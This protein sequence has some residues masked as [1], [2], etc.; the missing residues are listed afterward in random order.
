MYDRLLVAVDHSETAGRV[1][2]AAR[3]MA[4][5]S[6]GEVWVLHVREKEVVPRAGFLM[7]ESAQDAQS[8]AEGAVRVLHDASIKAHH[9]VRT[10]IHGQAA[11][12][13]VR[14][15][16]AHDAG[17]I[18]MGSRGRRDLT[19]LVLGSAAHEVIRLSRQ[20]VLVVR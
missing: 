7:L 1:V 15:A 10:A 4:A 17:I 11:R 12:E 8:T 6:N 2:N 9:E 5:L 3:E 13:I 19:G 20:P 14:A 18:V 16:R